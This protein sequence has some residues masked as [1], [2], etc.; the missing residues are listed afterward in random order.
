MGSEDGAVHSFFSAHP[1]TF[2]VVSQID[3]GIPQLG[4]QF[5]LPRPDLLEAVP[6]LVSLPPRHL[7][8]P[9]LLQ[10]A[11]PLAPQVPDRRP[12]TFADRPRRDHPALDQ[13]CLNLRRHF[14]LVLSIYLE[15]IGSRDR[16]GWMDGRLQIQRKLSLSALVYID[17]G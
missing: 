17:S 10:H 12:E 2:P 14:R 6:L 13:L 7:R 4:A 5:L 11:V 1:P 16:D 3:E 9:D 8:L 15:S